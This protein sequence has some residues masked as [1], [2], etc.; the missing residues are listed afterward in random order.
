MKKTLLKISTLMLVIYLATACGSTRKLTYFQSETA[1]GDSLTVAKP[2]IPIVQ[3]G[4]VL[5]VQIS[6]LNNKASAYFNPY[7][8]ITAQTQASSETA[9]LAQAPGYL[10][11]RDG[12]I[13]LPLV[14]KIV[15]AGL[16][17]DQVG[18]LITESLKDFLKEPTVSVRNL[19]FRISVMGEVVRPSLFTIP[20]EQIT[21]PEALSLAGD[22]TIYGRRENILISREANGKR[23]FARIDL[24][25]RDI[26]RSPYYYLRPND[27]VYVEPSKARVATVDRSSQILPIVLSALS[28]IA[29]IV[30][31]Y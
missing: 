25:R 5:S 11:A 23:V 27:I 12:S 2:F 3:S 21:L 16:T 22:V 31:R 4:D 13:Q 6:S 20:N 7:S 17:T 28:F 18:E 8:F 10:V 24:T 19:N 29:I 30:R 9:H 14:G 26:F 1:E 15:V